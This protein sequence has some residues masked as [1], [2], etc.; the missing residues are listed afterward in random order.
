VEIDQ[1]VAQRQS[2][3]GAV[4]KMNAVNQSGAAP[5]PRLAFKFAP[6][7]FV[8][9]LALSVRLWFN[10]ATSHIDATFASDAAE[11]LRDAQGL[12]TVA[13]LPPAFWSTA[14]ASVFDSLDGSQIE[15]VH[16]Q[17]SPL[18]ELSQGGPIFP[19]FILLSYKLTG[20]QVLT[21]N[22]FP[23]LAAQCIFTSLSCLLIALIGTILWDKRAGVTAGVIASLYPGFI[24]NSGRLY[25]E[26]FATFLICSIFLT[27]SLAFVKRG[28][29]FPGSIL[30]GILAALLH[31]T[32]SVMAVL[33]IA[34]VPITFLIGGQQKKEKMALYVAGFA[35]VFLPWMFLQRCAFGKNSFVIDRLG[36][37]NLFIGNNVDTQGWLTFPYPACENVASKSF[38]RIWKED[39]QVSPERWFKLMLNKPV[40]LFSVPWNDF[41]TAIGPFDLKWQTAFHELLLLLAAIGLITSLT[42]GSKELGNWRK[43]IVRSGV[44]AFFLFH[45]VYCCFIT[46]SR[47]ALPAMP[48]VILFAAAALTAPL[49]HHLSKPALQAALLLSVSAVVFLLIER[50]P[51]VIP[52]TR[53][54][55]EYWFLGL[56]ALQVILRIVIYAA[57][58]LLAYRLAT[59]LN[60]SQRVAAI[61]AVLLFLTS[62][63]AVCFPLRVFGRSNEWAEP[64]NEKGN[65]ILQTIRLDN[66]QIEQMLNRQSYVIVNLESGAFLADDLRIRLNGLELDS[67]PIPVMSFAENPELYMTLPNHGTCPEVEYILNDITYFAGGFPLQLRQWFLLPINPDQLRAALTLSENNRPGMLAISVEKLTSRANTFYGAFRTDPRFIF[68]P[69]VTQF[70]WEKGFFNVES[71]RGLSDF[72]LDN[73]VNLPNDMDETA[74]L[75]ASH[76]PHPY[77]RILVSPKVYG[78]SGLISLL[79]DTSLPQLVRSTPGISAASCAVDPKDRNRES[80]KVV[81]FSADLVA[82]PNVANLSVGLIAGLTKPDG[83]PLLYASKWFPQIVNPLSASTHL[84]YAFPLASDS[85]P[86]KLTSLTA[87]L[88]DLGPRDP[89][90]ACGVLSNQESKVLNLACV[91]SGLGQACMASD[92]N[93]GLADAGSRK[94]AAIASG[95]LGAS[96]PDHSISDLANKDLDTGA[97]GSEQNLRFRIY[98]LPNN[99]I[100]FGHE[101]Y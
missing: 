77:V 24:V 54:V 4:T 74:S 29:S 72:A 56:T 44:L 50:C 26:S 38:F 98:E 100:S 83:T 55:G 18:K 57:V 12:Q 61:S 36:H 68:V 15:Y 95:Q 96:P 94:T 25:S 66:H 81:R 97:G 19:L 31:V 30:L 85:L 10:F 73:K 89:A 60:A 78:R 63:P 13:G 69:S 1:T 82:K 70:S 22:I 53:M 37:Y 27:L 42:E 62:M 76:P 90:K 32:R 23:P 6:Y 34:L 40:R 11:Y 51:F 52:L 59:R 39:V 16:R 65:T 99:P 5:K 80:I 67:F 14:W 84:D 49:R 2:E 46:M 28:L 41:K 43:I 93:R 79:T 7:L 47:Y 58:L 33:S 3:D 17:L 91:R 88:S 64:F 48:C 21:T 101:I 35:L 87:T 86:A 20:M 75:Q 8:F 92:A 71:D 9:I 45:L